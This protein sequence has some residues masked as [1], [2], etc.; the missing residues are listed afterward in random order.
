MRTFQTPQ[1]CNLGFATLGCSGGQKCKPNKK[2]TGQVHGRYTIKLDD[3]EAV[4]N[5]QN[6]KRVVV[7]KQE[8]QPG[9][10]SFNNIP[11]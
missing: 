8:G 1:N 2:V 6:C 5:V 4:L 3:P 7:R 9:E 11:P 10:H